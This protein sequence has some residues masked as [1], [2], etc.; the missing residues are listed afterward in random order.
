MNGLRALILLTASMLRRLT[1]EGLVLRSLTFP[2]ALT[3]GTLMLTIGA[4]AWLRWDPLIAITADVADLE[5]ALV[6][7]GLRVEVMEDPQSAVENEDAWAGTDG[8]T[9]W[10]SGQ[11]PKA[12]VLESV[13]REAA[14]AS[15]RPDADVPKPPLEV[16]VAMGHTIVVLLGLLFALYGVVFGAG[17]VARDRDSGTLEIE[18]ALPVPR[19]VHGT[20]RLL[21]GTLSLS[22]FLAL[23]IVMVDAVIGVPDVTARIRHGIATSCGATCLGLLVIGRGG[24]RSGFTG[25]LTSGM[26]VAAGLMVAGYTF[27]G[28]AVWLPM[29]SFTTQ[30]SGWEAM[31]TATG[32]AVVTV[33]VFTRRSARA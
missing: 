30:A 13:V 9:V 1:R 22:V 20:T 10:L 11:G 16:A 15:W 8:H 23:G 3:V 21:T 28:L 33:A 27:P 29:A 5:P 17:M 2:T 24:L 19:W 31:A 4:V 25:P 26:S 7:N 12:L 32:L 18:L 14:G 6:A